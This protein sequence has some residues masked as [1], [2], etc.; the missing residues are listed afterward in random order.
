MSSTR[1]KVNPK[2]L[3]PWP[4][5]HIHP[6]RIW[7]D[8]GQVMQG[9]WGT[10]KIVLT[11]Q[12][13]RDCKIASNHFLFK[14]EVM[15]SFLAL[16]EHIMDIGTQSMES[17]SHPLAIHILL[18]TKAGEIRMSLRGITPQFQEILS[19]PVTLGGDGSHSFHLEK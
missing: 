3:H 13:L 7:G 14:C 11:I 8:F 9:C 2:F 19:L 15:G 6:E 5:T 12:I 1:K 4:I 18:E 16:Q 17:A 10:H